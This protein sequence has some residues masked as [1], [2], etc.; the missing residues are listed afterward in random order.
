MPNGGRGR[1]HGAIVI[2]ALMIGVLSAG[3]PYCLALPRREEHARPPRH[4]PR[5][6]SQRALADGAARARARN[7]V[8]RKGLHRPGSARRADRHLPD[9][10][11]A[12]QRRARGRPGLGRPGVSR[13]AVA[14]RNARPSPRSATAAARASTWWRSRTRRRS[15]TWWSARCARAIRGRC[16][17]CR[18]PGTRARRTARASSASRA[19]CWPISASRCPPRRRS[20]SG[21]PPPRCAISCLPMRPPGSEGLDEE[22]LAA[23]V[24]RDSM[25]GTG[26]PLAPAAR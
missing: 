18:P 15:T 20:G 23:L 6:R 26:L 22:A 12:A 21:I 17:G 4:R 19:A 9:E 24:T 1:Q 10:S 11:R 14:R 7:G 25:I 16:W 13:L 2:G 8:E 5:P 3:A